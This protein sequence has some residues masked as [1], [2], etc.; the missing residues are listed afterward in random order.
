VQRPFG[1]DHGRRAFGKRALQLAAL[2]ASPWTLPAGAQGTYPSKP[3][4]LIVP[5]AAGGAGD[6]VARILSPRLSESLGQ[7]IVIENRTGGSG[8]IACAY[9]AAAPADGYTLLINLGPSHQ[10][11]QLFAKG[12]KYDPVKDFTPVSMLATAPQSLVVPAA[13]PIKSVKDLVEAAKAS[14]KGLSYGTSGVGSSQH[15]AGLLLAHTE[16]VKL[17][18]IAYRGGAPALTDVVGGQ[19]DAG[20]LVLSNTLPYIQ[21]GKLR[22]LGVVETHRSHSAPS[23]PTVAEGGLPGFGVPD[24]WVGILGPA[25]LPAAIVQR[26]HAEIQKVLRNAEVRAQL[27][28]GGYDV[29]EASPETFA[30]QLADSVKFYQGVVANAGIVPE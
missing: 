23:I 8:S 1:P 24:T 6:T 17:T 21:N 29:V 15:I 3:I 14:P 25:G 5:Y 2:G 19:I 30:K 7:Q 18:H 27:E 16:K 11:L 13:S 22:S 12:I 4:R 20:I 9:V 28:K 26:L 10:T